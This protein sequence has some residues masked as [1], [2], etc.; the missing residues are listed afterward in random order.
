MLPIF[1]S[2]VIP[3]VPDLALHLNPKKYE[4]FWPSACQ[5]FPESKDNILHL[6]DGVSL[7]G[8]PIWGSEEF[9]TN[10]VNMLNDQVKDLQT[11]I[12]DL[13]YQEAASMYVKSTIYS[14]LFHLRL[15]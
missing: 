7:L 5:G 11:L 12:L 10:V 15:Y 4:L 2:K 9:I 14:K 3:G 8:S 6:Y 1:M 13:D